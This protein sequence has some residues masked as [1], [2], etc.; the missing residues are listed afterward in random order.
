[1]FTLTAQDAQASNAVV[2]STLFVR[3]VE[4]RVLFDPSASHSFVLPVF[5]SRIEW[6]PS[7][8]LTPLSVSTSL[9][10]ELETNVFFPSY[11]VIVEGR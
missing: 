5:A 7:R 1:M 9:S 10:D 4:A 2:A 11:P 3:S 6:Q 8:L